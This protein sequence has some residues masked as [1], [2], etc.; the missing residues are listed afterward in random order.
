MSISFESDYIYA[1]D[2][3]ANIWEHQLKL[4]SVPQHGPIGIADLNEVSSSYLT[5]AMDFI[6]SNHCFY[7]VALTNMVYNSYNYNTYF[8]NV[9][10]G[11]CY[12]IINMIDL[13]NREDEVFPYI[14]CLFSILTQYNVNLFH[15]DYYQKTPFNTVVEYTYYC[16]YSN[17]IL[18]RKQHTALNALIK[19]VN[20][21]YNVIKKCQAYIRRWL[22]TRTVQRKRLRRVLD[23]ILYAPLGQIESNIYPDFPG[24][25]KFHQC[26]EQF[27]D[28][29]IRQQIKKLLMV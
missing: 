18:T 16:I 10:H 23:G 1:M 13:Y 12:K 6:H 27:E 26:V 11:I 21:D 4:Y 8:G 22:G 2:G 9:A 25:T 7:N 15:I 28:M 24:G 5:S 14:H 17:K 19:V 20:P 29:A 3:I